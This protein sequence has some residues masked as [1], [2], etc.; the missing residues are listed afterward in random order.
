M[1]LDVAGDSLVARVPAESRP[2]PG[3]VLGVAID[4]AHVHL[5]SRTGERL[6]GPA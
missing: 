3:T 4:P 2:D 5:F 6:G 1:H